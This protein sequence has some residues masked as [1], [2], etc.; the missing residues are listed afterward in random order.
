M[1]DYTISANDVF[2]DA[3]A[4]YKPI[5]TRGIAGEAIIAGNA[6]AYD[7]A[8]NNFVLAVNLT[9]GR[10]KVSG[11]ALNDGLAGQPIDFMQKGFLLVGSASGGAVG[12]IA[13]LSATA[14][15]LAPCSDL[16]ST[17][18]VSI[19]G[20]FSATDTIEINLNNS[21]FAKA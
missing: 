16:V 6:V 2:I 7:T 1:A 15:T 20:V 11:I 14:G 3:N 8:N 4:T 9:P 19:V 18:L 10:S 12:D 13:V 5:I 17:N 21:Q